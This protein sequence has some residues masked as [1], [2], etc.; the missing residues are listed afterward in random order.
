MTEV[1]A[2]QCLDEK[3]TQVEKL[4]TTLKVHFGMKLPISE[5]NILLHALLSTSGS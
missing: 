5:F 1:G 2:L 3:K 4:T